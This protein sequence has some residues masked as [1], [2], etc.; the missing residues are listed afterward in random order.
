LLHLSAKVLDLP[1]EFP[2]AAPKGLEPVEFQRKLLNGLE[3]QVGG[4]GVGF[5][6]ED[7]AD[8]DWEG[9]TVRCKGV[10]E[11]LD[12]QPVSKFAARNPTFRVTASVGTPRDESRVLDRCGVSVTQIAVGENHHDLRVGRLAL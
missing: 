3:S 1:V 10:T 8:E 5:A 7:F 12:G 11:H 2:V 6:I 9:A 4:A